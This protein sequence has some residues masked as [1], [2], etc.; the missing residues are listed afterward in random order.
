MSKIKIFI[1]TSNEEDTWIEKIYL[2]SLFRNT[3][4]DLDITFLRPK[5][6]PEWDRWGWGTPFTCFRYAIP[7]LCGFKGKA[8]YTDVDQMNLSDIAELWETDLEG[9]P[10]GMVWD[11][12]M[13]NGSKWKST[14]YERGWWADSVV[15]MD[16]EK[17]K[18]HMAP[19]SEIAKEKGVYKWPFFEGLGQP[20]RQK[21][22]PFVKQLDPAWNSFD[23][24]NTSHLPPVYDREKQQ[25]LP[26]EQ[27]KQVHFTA[28]STQPWHPI[29]SP[30]GRATHPRQDIMEVLWR[31]AQEVAWISDPQK[32]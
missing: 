12:F 10:F 9:K 23:G 21:S 4:A 25:M 19:I 26:L 28:L 5:K 24:H 1:G 11:T 31:Y 6:F 13:A 20:F 32:L 3:K 14:A 29:Y 7:E 15:L 17:A 8:I 18:E 30:H 16:C 27:I 2:Y 22:V